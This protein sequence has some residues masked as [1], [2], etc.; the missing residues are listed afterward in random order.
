MLNLFHNEAFVFDNKYEFPERQGSQKAFSG[1]GDFVPVRPGRNNERPIHPRPRSLRAQGVEGAR[2]RRLQHDV[3]AR[4]RH[5]ARPH[6]AD[7]GQHLR[8]HRHGSDFH[9]FAVTGHGYSLLW[10]DFAKDLVRVDWQHG[11]CCAARPDV[12]SAFQHRGRSAR[13]LAVAFG[14]LR[15]PFTEAKRHVFTGMD[16]N[17]QDGGC[18]IEY[19]DQDRRIHRIYLEEL[20][21]HGVTSGMGQFIDERAYAKP[22]PDGARRCTSL[23]SST[24][25]SR[26]ATRS[27]RLPGRPTMWN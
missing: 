2:R 13:Y 17:V 20:A 4:R 12:P 11:V 6:L 25:T 5:H 15:Y 10:Y 8:G 7:A 16:V 26:P 27:T 9:V 18:Q 24:F 19:E 22:Q 14:G 21:R 23:N 1:E 3:R